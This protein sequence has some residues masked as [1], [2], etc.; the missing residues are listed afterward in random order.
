MAPLRALVRVGVV[1]LVAAL[2]ACRCGSD[3]AGAKGGDGAE[4]GAAGRAA[5]GD[6]AGAGADAKA[7]APDLLDLEGGSS[8]ALVDASNR[9]RDAEPRVDLDLEGPPDPA[10]TPRGWVCRG[11]RRP[12][13]NVGSG[14]GEH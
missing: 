10:C 14:R 6:G 5:P 3:G 13:S 8:E 12:G 4:A 9:F 7:E 1:L 11:G 2:P